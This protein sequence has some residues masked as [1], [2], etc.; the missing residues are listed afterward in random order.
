MPRYMR[1]WKIELGSLVETLKDQPLYIRT[2]F[3]V[4]SDTD[5]EANPAHLCDCLAGGDG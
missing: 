5:T 4:A 1:R 2:K 3:L